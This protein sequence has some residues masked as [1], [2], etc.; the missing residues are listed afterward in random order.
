[1]PR[2]LLYDNLK[3]AVL[4]R[5]G[6]AIRFHPTL[7]DFAAHYRYEPRP[8]AP[9]RGNEKGRVE[10]A[11][12]YIRCSF[13]AAREWTSLKDLNRKA[14]RWCTELAARRPWPEDRSRDVASAFAEERSKLLALAKVPF[15]IEERRQ[16]RVGKSPY[17]RFDGNDYSLPHGHTRRHLVVLATE[18]QIRI[19]EGEQVLATH[20]RSY[21]RGRLIEERSH[22]EALR[23]FKRQARKH[24]GISRLV[25]SAPGCEALLGQLAQRGENLG[26]A[27]A[28]LLKLLDRYG[29][30]RMERAAREASRRDAPHPRSV[31]LLLER[32]LEEEGKPPQLPVAL[33][34]D[35]RVREVVV[36][37]HSLE[38]YQKLTHPSCQESDPHEQESH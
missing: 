30:K 15:P 1:V 35:P 6:D 14:E 8:V 21:D 19:L 12:R 10:R 37:P 31:R 38:G 5:H 2:V 9:Y 26:S 18:E 13:F 36:R 20:A 22:V 11:I 28:Q 34:E 3:S 7:L 27:V 25:R 33:P 4:E 17:I 24:H 32:Q 23:A 29:A 16:V